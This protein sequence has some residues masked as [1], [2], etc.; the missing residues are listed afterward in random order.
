MAEHETA[1]IRELNDE[2]RRTLR[3][4]TIVLTAGLIGLGPE[5]HQAIL[6]AVSSFDRF[7][8]DNDPHGEHDFGSLTVDDEQLFF[9]IDYYDPSLSRHSSNPGDAA[10]T[11]RV[12]TIMLADEY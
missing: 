7:D 10:A 3:G 8:P 4:G 6:K 11:K 2:L 9:K 12:L 1:R 5:R